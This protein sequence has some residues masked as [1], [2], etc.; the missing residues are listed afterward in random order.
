LIRA[1]ILPNCSS[2]LPLFITPASAVITL[3]VL[4]G[5]GFSGVPALAQAP[6]NP[7]LSLISPGPSAANQG[8]VQQSGLSPVLNSFQTFNAT[9]DSEAVPRTPAPTLTDPSYAFRQPVQVSYQAALSGQPAQADCPAESY[10]SPCIDFFGLCTPGI[11]PWSPAEHPSQTPSAAPAKAPAGGGA[12][13][14]PSGG[15]AQDF[16]RSMGGTNYK[17]RVQAS[18]SISESHAPGHHS[19]TELSARIVR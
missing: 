5:T 14:G 19:Q 4:L 7:G 8:G 18:S 9:A 11:F 3:F 16:V 15:P 2:R 17:N 1:Q 6:Y 13:Q 12:A 10:T